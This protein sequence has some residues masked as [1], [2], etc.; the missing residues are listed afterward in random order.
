MH[1]A[2]FCFGKKI[3]CPSNKNATKN[4]RKKQPKVKEYYFQN[5]RLHFT[6]CFSKKAA[7]DVSYDTSITVINEDEDVKQC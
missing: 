4:S 2:G 6:I 3:L 7:N 1:A 5:Q